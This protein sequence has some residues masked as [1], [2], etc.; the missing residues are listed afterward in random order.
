MKKIIVLT[1]FCFLILIMEK[2]NVVYGAIN[3]LSSLEDMGH[4]LLLN[5]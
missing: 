2:F 1:L 4:I 5:Q 3:E